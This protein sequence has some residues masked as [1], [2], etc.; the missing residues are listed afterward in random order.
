[1]E[2]K[3]K[4]LAFAAVA[5]MF[6]VCFIGFVAINDDAVDADGTTTTVDKGPLKDMKYTG[7]MAYDEKG[8]YTLST[9]VI[10]TLTD[11]ISMKGVKF[12]GEGHSLTIKSSAGGPY[13]LDVEYDFGNNTGKDAGRIFQVS[14]FVLDGANLKVI[15]KD[16]GKSAG[17]DINEAEC[18]V[19][20]T[21]K[22][23]V[24]N[25]S[26]MTITTNKYANRVFYNNASSLAIETGAKVILERASSSTVSLSMT[27]GATLFIKNPL[28]TA[29]N[30][31]P[32]IDGGKITVEGAADGNHGLFFY[33]S[34]SN[35]EGAAAGVL[36]NCAVK[37]DGI[38]GFYSHKSV[39]AT[40][41]KFEAK[42]LVVAKSVAADMADVKGATFNVTKVGALNPNDGYKPVN[43][44][45][46]YLDGVTFN[47]NTV[48]GSGASLVVEGGKTLT[49]AE[50]AT[51]SVFGTID[52]K[53]TI[54]NNGTIIVKD[55]AGLKTAVAAG[56]KI[57][58]ANDVEITD[59]DSTGDKN[60]LKITKCVNII[61]NGHTIKFSGADTTYG[62]VFSN[63]CN[64][65][66]LSNVKLDFGDIAKYGLCIR[67]MYEGNGITIENVTID[68]YGKTGID[69]NGVYGKIKLKDVKVEGNGHYVNAATNLTRGHGYALVIDDIKDG[70]SVT[71]ENCTI[72][73]VNVHN[74]CGMIH[75]VDLSG[76]NGLLFVSVE[77]GSTKRTSVFDTIGDSVSHNKQNG[78]LESIIGDN[79]LLKDG[80]VTFPTG[81]NKE[82]YA[83]FDTVKN[84]DGGVK[85]EGGSF[86]VLRAYRVCYGM[87]FFDANV[88]IVK[89]YTINCDV[90]IP[91]GVSVLVGKDVTLTI[92]KDSTLTGTINGPGD[93]KLTANGMKAGEGG[94]T[95]TGGSLIINGKIMNASGSEA[96][97]TVTV[98]GGAIKIN[99]S[100]EAGATMVIEENTTVTVENG[101]SFSSEGI[102]DNKGIITNDGVLTNN[103]TIKM[104][105]ASNIAGDKK[106]VNNGIV[107]DERAEDKPAVPITND[108]TVVAKNNADEYKKAKIDVVEQDPDKRADA[109][110][111]IEVSTNKYAFITPITTTGKLDIVMNNG[112]YTVTIP[113]G[114][115]IAAGTVISVSLIEY[116]SDS[117]TRYQINTPGIENFSMKLPCQVGFKKAKVYCDDSEMGVSKVRYDAG[118]GYVTF[119]ASHNSVFTIVLSNTSHAGTTTVSGGDTTNDYSLVIAF[120]VLVASLG[121]LAYVIKRR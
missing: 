44:K 89:D 71:T 77:D 21:A 55:A 24:K 88:K 5:L 57:S 120:V 59:H 115:T 20:G 81:F 7:T 34:V 73:S 51:I 25:G 80:I 97:A 79:G 33:G 26:E 43:D 63:G 76:C 107:I 30:F 1:M 47:G 27:G 105:G 2:K 17:P 74:F 116:Q 103:G 102:I 61:G 42:E 70:A 31:Y 53:G 37:T 13:K 16:T 117:V 9:D 66:T 121:F 38:V 118:A 68:N 12:V 111:K 86:E 3:M 8:V 64:D 36:K 40:E 19:F 110:G 99:G 104:T 75:S 58:L 67:D 85:K 108:G 14:T 60:G 90:I 69:L 72:T 32:N 45:K 52:N 56:G 22:V 114:T 91:N 15:Q 87:A 46:L 96:G 106:V 93:S 101:K 54:V 112:Q 113:E 119:D 28:S 98:S 84:K 95:I 18:S 62:F 83:I 6:A 50:G 39:D 100:L 109:E 49:V 41:S 29:G 94:I 10:V 65:S 23:T 35:A 78:S 92:T 4:I 82:D 48:I 11:N